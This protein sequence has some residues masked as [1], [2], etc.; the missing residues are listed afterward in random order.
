MDAKFLEFL[1]LLTS[2][3]LERERERGGGGRDEGNYLIK[4]AS[5]ILLERDRRQKSTNRNRSFKGFYCVKSFHIPSA[6]P[7]FIF[8][9]F[10]N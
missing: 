8:E 7:D 2:A 1:I 5:L 10:L 3:W 9:S 4:A 6:K